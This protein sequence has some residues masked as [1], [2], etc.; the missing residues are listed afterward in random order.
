[1]RM[2]PG[3]QPKS[4]EPIVVDMSSRQY[5]EK[6]EKENPVED[7]PPEGHIPL[8]AD[9][10]EGQRFGFPSSVLLSPRALW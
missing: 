9:M 1:M 4:L 3:M 8:P 7:E 2:T 6:L 10:P 5:V